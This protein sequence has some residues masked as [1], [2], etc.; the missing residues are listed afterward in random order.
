MIVKL[1]TS[2]ALAITTGENIEISSIK[3][4]GS[5][6]L[7]SHLEDLIAR[8]VGLLSVGH[9]DDEEDSLLIIGRQVHTR[10]QK[11][12]DLVAMDSTGAM[13]LVE[14][15]RDARDVAGRKDHAEIQAIRYAASVAGMTR[16]DDIVANIHAPYVE[17]YERDELAKQ[18]GD[19]SASEWA[20]KKLFEFMRDNNIE[21]SRL[22]HAQKIVLVG[23]GFD[24]DTRSA[25]A[26]M[27]SNGLPIRVIELRPCRL[28]SDILLEITQIIPVPR[29]EDFYVE[30]LTPDSSSRAAR[31]GGMATAAEA[32]RAQRLRVPDLY[33]AGMLKAGQEVYFKNNPDRKAALSAT[34]NRC[35]ENGGSERTLLDWSKEVTGWAAVNVYD[36]LV[37]EPSKKTLDQLRS[38]LEAKQAAAAEASAAMEALASGAAG[39]G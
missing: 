24:A 3:V 12:M 28:G 1:T 20:R 11:R 34:P 14:V 37:H 39:E 21:E 5:A 35:R 7:E 2:P 16:V 26:W 27:A 36:W 18:G 8:N 38:E 29:Y 25:A 23:A 10:T 30:L 6:L 33:A 13:I 15:K 17:R 31:F 9:Q 4:G 19:R 32:V 22:N